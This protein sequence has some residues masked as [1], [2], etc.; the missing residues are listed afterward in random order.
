LVK[1]LVPFFKSD[2]KIELL[3]KNAKK[4]RKKIA[5]LFHLV[6]NRG[7]KLELGGFFHKKSYNCIAWLPILKNNQTKLPTFA[8]P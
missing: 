5:F 7:F 3:K 6:Y 2:A 4:H 1:F 8:V